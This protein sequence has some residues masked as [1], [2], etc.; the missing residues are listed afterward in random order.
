MIPTVYDTERT[1]RILGE[2]GRVDTIRI[3]EVQEG[4]G[5][6]EPE[7]RLDVTIGSYDVVT[8]TGPSYTTK[9]EES[10]E[11]M[12]AFLQSAPNMMPL[13]LDLVAKSQDWPLADQFAARARAVIPPQI[14]QASEEEEGIGTEGEEGQP[15]GQL[16]AP[17]QEPEPEQPG[18]EE[19]E[20]AKAADLAQAEIE[21][22]QINVAKEKDIAAAQVKKA[23]ADAETAELNRDIKIVDL[24]IRKETLLEKQNNENVSELA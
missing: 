7:V 19:I 12:M 11:G 18:P 6:S 16:P 4:D 10:R 14:L 8:Q 15:E 3:N 13:V 20:A 2:D 22:A 21:L 9:R 17:P 23:G 5:I 24:E 1:V